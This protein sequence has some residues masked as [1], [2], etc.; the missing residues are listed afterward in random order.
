[1]MIKIL[2]SDLIK[3][4]SEESEAAMEKEVR[5]LKFPKISISE[6][7]GKE[8][9]TSREEVQR[10]VSKIKGDTLENKINN[11]NDF[12]KACDKDSCPLDA[13]S[14]ISHLVV[15]NILTSIAEQYSASGGGFLMEAFVAALLGGKQIKAGAEEGVTD[16]VVGD[17]PYSIK[18]VSNFG[19]GGSFSNL[20]KSFD[21]HK[22]PVVYYYILKR[23]GNAEFYNI[24]IDQ[25]KAEELWKKYG[26]K[27]GFDF[28]STEV[29]EMMASGQSLGRFKLS[30]RDLGSPVATIAMNSDYIRKLAERFYDV[31]QG[32]ITN[33]FDQ[34]D[35]LINNINSFV[36]DNKKEAAEPAKKNLEGIKLSIDGQMR[37]KK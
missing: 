20:R 28:F 11:I 23:G 5:T 24:V 15:L 35:D 17:Q 7:F 10:Y 19:E 36:I 13:G 34:M 32:D 37:K 3:I 30:K 6:D 14:I 26:P 18:F 9:S 31:L 4:I 25:D 1:M 22:K 2:E 29:R 12:I 16:V 27:T 21:L 8:D 33:V